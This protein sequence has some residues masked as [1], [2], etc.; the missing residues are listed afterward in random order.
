MATIAALA[1][2]AS[3]TGCSGGTSANDKSDDGPLRTAYDKYLTA[4]NSQSLDEIAA[5]SCAEY[6][7]ML[8]KPREGKSAEELI[9]KDFQADG[10][11]ILDNFVSP[12][13]YQNEGTAA[14]V[15]HYENDQQNGAVLPNP[16]ITYRFK[17]ENGDW[18]FCGAQPITAPSSVPEPR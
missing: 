16:P 3:L 12:F 9:K 6:A 17:K 5:A 15:T 18:K 8:K 7:D 10:K 13:I 2:I 14:I 11:M 4:F 1:G